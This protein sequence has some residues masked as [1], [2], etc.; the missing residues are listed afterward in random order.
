MTKTFALKLTAEQV[1]LLADVVA[2]VTDADRDFIGP[3]DY[4]AADAIR[5]EIAA[6]LAAIE[7]ATA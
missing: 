1:R 6:T 2:L 4:N 5:S 7:R 3:D